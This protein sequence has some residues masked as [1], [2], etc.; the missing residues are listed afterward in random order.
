MADDPF[1][2]DMDRVKPEPGAGEDGDPG[3]HS[4]PFPPASHVKPEPEDESDDDDN[5]DKDND[6]QSVSETS[7]IEQLVLKTSVEELEAGVKIGLQ[8]LE[9]L[10]IPLNSA[11]VAEDNQV[12]QAGDW[13]KSI[14]QLQDSAKPVRTVVGVVYVPTLQATYLT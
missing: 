9:S 6:E 2:D 5:D 10:K 1:K 8:L 13:L 7:Y 11:M 4:V 14:Q 12:T 3:L